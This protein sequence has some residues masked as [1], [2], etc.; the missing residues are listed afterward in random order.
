[1]RPANAS[2]PELPKLSQRS[3]AAVLQDLLAKD[4]RRGHRR[5]ALRHFLMLRACGVCPSPQLQEECEQLLGACPE[6]TRRRIAAGVDGWTQMVH[7]R[8]PI[9]RP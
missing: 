8:P 2:R 6:E 3:T 9:V 4:L 1:V 5:L 7:S